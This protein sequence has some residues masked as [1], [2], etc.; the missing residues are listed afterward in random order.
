[1]EESD[2]IIFTELHHTDK[3]PTTTVSLAQW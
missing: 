1:L 2:K 3:K